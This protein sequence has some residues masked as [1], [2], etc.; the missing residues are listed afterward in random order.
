MTPGIVGE[1]DLSGNLTDEYVF[2]DGERVAHKSTNGVFYYFSDHLKTASVVT[3]SLGNIKSESDFYP[4]GGELQ[5]VNN[6]SNHYKFTGK[7]RDSETQL[8]YFGAR[9]YSNG[10]G[11]FVSADWSA[12]P[13]PVPYANF[14][15]PQTLNL[16]GFVG[17]NPATKADPDGHC[18]VDGEHHF[19]W[20]IFH[21]LGFYETKKDTHDRLVD[22]ARGYFRA[23]GILENG[24]R[25]DT[26]KLSNDEAVALFTKINDQWKNAVI[27]CGGCS[28]SYALAVMTQWGWSGTKPYTDAVKQ[29]KQAGTHEN[30]G[31]KVPTREEATRMIE[32]SRGTVDRQDAGHAP[33]GVSTHTEPHINYYTEAGQK[34][35]VIVK[36]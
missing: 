26:S 23:N 3:D 4:W 25:V 19:G 12:T 8:D 17:G 15:D 30:L 35:T 5:F 24:K 21:T 11:R 6:D 31:G 16:Y 29:L 34:A 7:E 14:G 33:G 27:G 20:C 1:S 2:F 9:F 18:N 36:D 32:E 13:A 28:P 10:L 22:E